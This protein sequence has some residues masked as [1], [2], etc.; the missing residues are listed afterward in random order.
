INPG[1]TRKGGRFTNKTGGRITAIYLKAN[2]TG[3]TFKVVADASERLF[4]TV[5]LKNDKTEVYFM[6]GNIPVFDGTHPDLG[7]FWMYVTRNEEDDIRA[8]S[9]CH[10]DNPTK[11][12]IDACPFTGQVFEKNPPEPPAQQWTKIKGSQTHLKAKWK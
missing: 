5:W 7:V 1:G 8:C 4:D 3:D 10:F 12:C 2:K 9:K 6:D 11:P